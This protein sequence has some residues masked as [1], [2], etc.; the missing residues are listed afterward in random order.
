[1]AKS[2]IVY[3]SQG[4]TTT[5][6]AESIATGLRSEGYEVDHT[7]SKKSSRQTSADMICSVS[8]LLYTFSVHHSSSQTT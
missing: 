1:M 8:G 4:G 6:V 3:F 5:K 7:A 2:L